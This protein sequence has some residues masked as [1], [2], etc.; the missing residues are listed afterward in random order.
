M[1]LVFSASSTKSG[2]VDLIYRYTGADTTKYPLSEVVSDVNAAVDRLL[3]L[4]IRSSGSWQY[5]DSNHTD[6]PIIT[7]DL[8][9]GQR[10]Y[11]FTTDEQGN[12]ILDIY[13][14]MV[15]NSSG[16]FYD[17]EL[18][19]Q[20]NQR[21]RN[22]GFVDGQEITGQP[23]KYDKTA[24][25]IFLD[26]IPNYSYTNGI[27]I[28]I[29]REASYFTS[30]DTTKKPGFDGRLHEYL[31]VRPT[32]YYAQRKGLDNAD[33]WSNELLKYEGDEDRGI[34]GL[35]ESVYSKRSKDEPTRIL[36]KYRSSR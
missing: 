18:A 25:G 14:V 11:S 15:A 1:S 12:L 8:V 10:D 13:R 35:I 16:I 34:T 9:S 21:G 33:F 23:S 20:Q 17:L 5:D 29:N 32:A 24:N 19:D 26:A 2:I 31:V 27:K 36:T 22:I 30:S 7:T 6:Y 28:F 4:A 3:A